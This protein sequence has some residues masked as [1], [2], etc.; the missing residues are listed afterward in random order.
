MQ[1]LGPGRR[2]KHLEVQTLVGQGEY[3][4]EL[5]RCFDKTRAAS[6]TRQVSW[7]DEN[8]KRTRASV[9]IIGVRELQQS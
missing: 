4:G 2:A 3:A 1:R 9:R 7:N 8:F 5:C 6:C